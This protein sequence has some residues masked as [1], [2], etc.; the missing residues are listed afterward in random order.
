MTLDEQIAI[1]QAAKEGK[2][3]KRTLYREGYAGYII[4]N[5]KIHAFD[6]DSAMYEIVREPMEI[7]V[8]VYPDG[9]IAAYNNRPIADSCMSKNGRTVKFREVLED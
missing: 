9:K 1:L 2:K 4:S 6:F 8:N 3:I 5:N 7:W